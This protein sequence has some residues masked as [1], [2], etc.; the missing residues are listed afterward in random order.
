[1]AHVFWANT[2]SPSGGT[3]FLNE[4]GGDFDQPGYG[5]YLYIHGA[6]RTR[7]REVFLRRFVGEVALEQLRAPDPR[8][9]P[10]QRDCAGLVRFAFRA[11]FHRFAPG[12]ASPLFGGEGGSGADF[13]DA[14]SLLTGSF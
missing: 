9:H 12:R 4:Q 5:P 2:A 13:A 3:F 8:W 1:M 7:A 10:S 6:P 14:R 11:A